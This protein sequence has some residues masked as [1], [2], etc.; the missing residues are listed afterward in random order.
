MYKFRKIHD[1]F[2]YIQYTVQCTP[3][4]I[5]NN[6]CTS[7]K[8]IIFCD[9]MN[10]ITKNIINYL[11]QINQQEVAKVTSCLQGLSTYRKLIR[12]HVSEYLHD[13]K[14]RFRSKTNLRLYLQCIHSFRKFD[15][16]VFK[17]VLSVLLFIS[18]FVLELKEI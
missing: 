4:Y 12:N 11:V 9:T 1:Y 14:H 8:R 6:N 2:L 17:Q 16:V 10:A 7:L 13:N 18:K 5:K 3:L 15:T